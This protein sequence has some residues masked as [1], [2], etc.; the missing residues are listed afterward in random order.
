MTIMFDVILATIRPEIYADMT[1]LT[2]V[3]P[4]EASRWH[5]TRIWSVAPSSLSLKRSAPM[6]GDAVQPV[7]RSSETPSA[8]VLFQNAS[9]GEAFPRSVFASR[10]V[11]PL[12]WWR[13]KQV[14]FVQLKTDAAL[15][16]LAKTVERDMFAAAEAHKRAKRELEEARARFWAY[17][18]QWDAAIARGVKMRP[19]DI[20][21]VWRRFQQLEAMKVPKAPWE[22]P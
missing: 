16:A 10:D 2:L 12:V 18:A 6:S 4:K 17:T 15:K 5:E 22:L 19:A 3:I 20:A 11:R 14:S 7:S 1:R 8:A 21:E 13:R 9:Y